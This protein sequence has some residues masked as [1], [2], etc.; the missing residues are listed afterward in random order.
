MGFHTL[1]Q[2]I[3]NKGE[4]MLLGKFRIVIDIYFKTFNTINTISLAIVTH[5]TNYLS[6]QV[7]HINLFATS[8]LA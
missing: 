7:T 6:I 8:P 5:I 4:I 1:I 2:D 3:C